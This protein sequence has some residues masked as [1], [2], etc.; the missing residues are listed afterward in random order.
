MPIHQTRW[1]WTLPGGR[2]DPGETLEQA[3][4]RE[5]MKKRG[6]SSALSGS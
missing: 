5:S 2:V 1:C 6:W 4:M 3:A